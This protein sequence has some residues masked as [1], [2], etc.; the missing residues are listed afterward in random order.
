MVSD[1]VAAV[2]MPAGELRLFGTACVIGDA[3]RVKSSGA[4]A[5]GRAGIDQGL[6]TLREWFPALPLE[7]FLAAATAAPAAL[8]G[9]TDCGAAVAP[10]GAADLALLN[11]QLEV[12]VTVCQG[13]VAY[14]A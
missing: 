9:L 2:G 11:D 4:L 5:G 10:G 13:R 14:R 1:G 3:V 8:L 7:R 6:R 12:V